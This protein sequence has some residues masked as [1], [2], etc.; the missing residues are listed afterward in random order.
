MA[1]HA[2]PVTKLPRLY[3]PV[4]SAGQ[5]LLEELKVKF[6]FATKT[7]ICKSAL[8]RGLMAMSVPT[9]VA[10]LGGAGERF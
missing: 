3:I 5:Q 7:A 10:M 4:S 2:S 6:P 1:Q 8:Q 9:G